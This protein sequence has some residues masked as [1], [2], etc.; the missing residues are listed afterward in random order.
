MTKQPDTDAGTI[1]ALM[2]RLQKFRLPRALAIKARVD[3]GEPLSDSDVQFLKQALEDAHGGQT[4]AARHPEYHALV[5][6]IV[7]LYDEITRKAL[8]NEQRK[9]GR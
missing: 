4:I 6:K 7:G 8:D 1:Q 2:E 5:A 9:P 3:A